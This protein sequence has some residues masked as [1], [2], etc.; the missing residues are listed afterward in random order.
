[1]RW[2]HLL[3]CIGLLLVVGGV[4]YA[5]LPN[6]SIPDD[7]DEVILF[8]VDGTKMHKEPHER[9]FSPEHELLYECAVLGRAAITDSALRQQVIAT[10]KHDIRT[11]HPTP[12]K[13]FWPRH[14]VR[15]V[16]RG[17]TLDVVICHQC[18]IYEIHHNGDPHVGYTPSIGES[19]KPLLNS[20][21][22]DAGIPIAP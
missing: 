9:G 12:S 4:I 15:F 20:I 2:K 1:M 18:H 11:G 8:S 14:V 10:V 7:P 19:S 21:L 16:K 3:L 22:I 6:N 5:L 17:K 13:C